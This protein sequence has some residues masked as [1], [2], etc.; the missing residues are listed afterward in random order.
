MYSW[1][2]QMRCDLAGYAT[3]L[4]WLADA[5]SQ[6]PSINAKDILEIVLIAIAIYQV[7][8]WLR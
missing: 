3:F 2:R 1:A 7:I 4:D 8:R 5:A 6:M